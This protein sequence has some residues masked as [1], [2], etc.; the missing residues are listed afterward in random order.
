MDRGRQQIPYPYELGTTQLPCGF[1]KPVDIDA[2]LTAFAAGAPP[3]LVSALDI[4]HEPLRNPNE[5]AALSGFLKALFGLSFN[6]RSALNNSPRVNT[7]CKPKPMSSL[8][9]LRDSTRAIR[10]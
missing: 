7:R 2:G 6:V 1:Q 8:P 4:L 9:L 3:A 5:G 10:R